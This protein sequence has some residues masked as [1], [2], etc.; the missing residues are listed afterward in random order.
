MNKTR[1][2]VQETTTKN[3]FCLRVVGRGIVSVTVQQVEEEED[4]EKE[5]EK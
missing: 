1:I 4:E 5:K 3:N 2:S